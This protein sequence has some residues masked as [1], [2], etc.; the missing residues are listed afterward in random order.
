[1]G[2]EVY[3]FTGPLIV[4]PEPTNPYDKNALVVKDGDIPIGYIPRDKQH[5]FLNNK[6]KQTAEWSELPKAINSSD[7]WSIQIVIE[8]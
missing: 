7:K 2:V 4:G 6:F 8:A 5:Y 1:M 3:K